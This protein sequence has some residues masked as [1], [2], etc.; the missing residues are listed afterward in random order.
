[1]DLV[2][3]LAKLTNQRPRR[4]VWRANPNASEALAMDMRLFGNLRQPAAFGLEFDVPAPVFFDPATILDGGIAVLNLQGPI[5]HHSS[6]YWSSYEDLGQ[7][8]ECA[9]KHDD[10]RAVVLKVDSPGGVASGMNE[11]HRKIRRLQAKY[12][13]QVLAYVDETACSAAYH[14][15]SACS[16]IWGPESA[17][18]GSVGVIL[19]TVDETE[20]LEKA[21][22]RVRYVV[23]GKRKADLHPGQ[24]VTD[25]VLRVAQ[26]KVDEH[27]AMFFESVGKA[28]GHAGLD[29]K[30]VE[31]LQAGVFLGK[32]AMK[33]GLSD[34][35]K[36]Y[37]GFLRILRASLD[38]GGFGK[39]AGRKA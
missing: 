1:M 32:D 16:E 36:S 8:I 20:A 35:V 31:S 33:I 9:L 17:Q 2:K 29:A 37:G 26:E 24:P 39:A 34:G 14:I 7:H 22:V 19:C 15:A 12:G 11:A 6:W 28:R 23:T 3:A 10:V 4:A 13:K 27:G 18:I 30:K 21:G 38:G 5:D 25:D